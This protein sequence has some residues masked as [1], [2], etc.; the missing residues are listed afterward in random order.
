MLDVTFSLPRVLMMRKTV[1]LD[2]VLRLTVEN[3]LLD[4]GLDNMQRRTVVIED[5]RSRL[6]NHASLE[7]IR[8]TGVH[9]ELVD[10][11]AQTQV[12]EIGW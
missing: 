8:V 10:V 6:G 5:H 1:P 4:Q 12:F 7:A 11:E 9:L 3:A 2:Q